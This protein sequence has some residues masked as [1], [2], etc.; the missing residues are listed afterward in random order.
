[1]DT[2]QYLQ[3]LIERATL[4]IVNDKYALAAGYLD[5]AEQVTNRL[6]KRRYA[7]EITL[8]HH[9]IE[10]LRGMLPEV[11]RYDR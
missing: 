10:L 1:M 6:D 7:T 4:A 3:W 8:A 11:K 5:H 9:A 2:Y